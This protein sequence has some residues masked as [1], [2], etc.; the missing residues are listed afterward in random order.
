MVLPWS[1]LVHMNACGMVEAAL[2]DS[3]W[4]TM[5]MIKECSTCCL[6]ML[7]ERPFLV[8]YNNKVTHRSREREM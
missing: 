3:E 1:T 4:R 7:R 6:H 5:L 2:A 8:E